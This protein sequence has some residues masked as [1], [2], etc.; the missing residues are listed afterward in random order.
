MQTSKK[1]TGRY[2]ALFMLSLVGLVVAYIFGGGY[3]SMVLPFNF[4]LFAKA[5]DLM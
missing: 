2:W 5:L 4:T 3:A 1:S